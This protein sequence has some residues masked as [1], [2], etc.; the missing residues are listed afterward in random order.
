MEPSKKLELYNLRLLCLKA[1][2]TASQTKE[3]WSRM[4]SKLG[5]TI[6]EYSNKNQ[7]HL[8]IITDKL[9]LEGTDRGEQL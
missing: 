1:L 7:L 6:L 5:P 2:P 4:F 8:H 3:Y 9:K